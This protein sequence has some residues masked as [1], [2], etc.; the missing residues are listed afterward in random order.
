MNHTKNKV[1]S[2]DWKLVSKGTRMTADFA[3]FL[4]RNQSILILTVVKL[5]LVSMVLKEE[6]YIVIT[7]NNFQVLNLGINSNTQRIG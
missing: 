1:V 4:K 2:R 5:L 3:A 6:P 7:E